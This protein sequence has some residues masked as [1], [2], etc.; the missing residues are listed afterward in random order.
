V[1]GAAETKFDMGKNVWAGP[2]VEHD[3]A[4]YGYGYIRVS[5]IGRIPEVALY[6]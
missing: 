6:I 5:K 3:W 4:Q 1:G 2:P